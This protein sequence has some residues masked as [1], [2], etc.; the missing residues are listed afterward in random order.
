MSSHANEHGVPLAGAAS[1][2]ANGAFVL[3]LPPL[4]CDA[5]EL[6]IRRLDDGTGRWYRRMIELA[7]VAPLERPG[8]GF[9]AATVRRQ[10]EEYAV[11]P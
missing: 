10:G 9:D 2:N 7:L 5:M 1:L 4:L 3:P 11:A 6:F 8:R